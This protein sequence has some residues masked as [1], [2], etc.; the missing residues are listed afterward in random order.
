MFSSENDENSI[1]SSNNNNNNNNRNYFYR[2]FKQTSNKNTTLAS[3]LK[4]STTTNI[5]NMGSNN[6]SWFKTLRSKSHTDLNRNQPKIFVK[7]IRID[8]TND[9]DDEEE[10]QVT[11][12]NLNSKKL[13]SK[14]VNSIP[15]LRLSVVEIDT[16]ENLNSNEEALNPSQMASNSSSSSSSTSSSL[17]R[18]SKKSNDF[19]TRTRSINID[20]AIKLKQ[21]QQQ[22]QTKTYHIPINISN[23]SVEDQALP[24][25][26]S[27]SQ[28]NAF[29]LNS[30]I[31][32]QKKNDDMIENQ[33]IQIDLM[34][35][36]LEHAVREDPSVFKEYAEKIDH[37]AKINN[38]N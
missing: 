26:S 27:S 4:T 3:N 21:Q 1:S 36:Q 38:V 32:V 23:D 25:V 24:R 31:E 6:Q 30:L 7:T 18:T 15:N 11:S 16:S 20:E 5:Q 2:S 10:P 29:D 12:E 33:R 19:K 13:T 8:E 9:D 14:S 37:L 22:N 17:F 28:L 35:R 34:G